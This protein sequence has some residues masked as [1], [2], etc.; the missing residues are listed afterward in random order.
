MTIETRFG[1]YG[2]R[3]VPET[4]IPALDELT[5]AYEEARDDAAFQAELARLLAEY[6]GRPTPLYHARPPERA[7]R[8]HRS[9]SS[10]RTSATP[11]PTRSTTSSARRCSPGAWASAA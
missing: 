4:L 10:A 3:F 7:L 9:C 1:P 2:G 11:A 8:R 5:A 6:A